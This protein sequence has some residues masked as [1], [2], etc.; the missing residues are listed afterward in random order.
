MNDKE[1]DLILQD[2]LGDGETQPPYLDARLRGELA[3]ARRGS[4]A[5]SVWWL[6]FVLSLALGAVSVLLGG[7]LPW[8]VNLLLTLSA[9]F[10][11]GAAGAFTLLGLVCFDL[12]RKGRV[13]L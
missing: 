4:R 6:P 10:T 5:L 3:L 13:Y 8:P 11:V 2:A 12:K 7:V 1:L 9:L